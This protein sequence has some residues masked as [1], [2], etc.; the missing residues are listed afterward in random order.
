MKKERPKKV[1]GTWKCSLAK[2]GLLCVMA[3]MP[4][5]AQEATLDDVA[6]ASE[7][8]DYLEELVI[9][10]SADASVAGL[11]ESYNG[12][13]VARGGRVGV[14]GALDYM[15]TP[16]SSTNYTE[17]F[18]E[19]RQA[20][21]IGDVLEKDP[22]VRVARGFGNFQESYLIRGLQVYSDD[23]TFNG[24]YG[25][26]P[27]QYLAAE[28]AER[29][30]VFRGASAFLNGAAPTGS[31][32]GGTV[33]VLPKRAPNE[34]LNQ[35]TLGYTSDGQAYGA[36]D[37]ARRYLDGK[38]GVRLNTAVRDGDTAIDGESAGTALFALGL[39]WT[40]ERFRLSADLGYQEVK[41]QGIQPN[42]TVLPGVDIP[43]APSSSQSI[44]QSWTYADS[45]E[46]FGVLRAEYDFYENWSAWAAIGGRSG[47]EENRFANPRVS[48]VDGTANSY[49]FDNTREDTVLTGEVGV[50]GDFLT[51][52][53][54]HRPS[55]SFMAYSL[56]S[57][58]AYAFS[59]FG[60]FATNIYQPGTVAQPDATALIG[61]D[62]SNPSTTFEVETSSFALADMVSMF[63]ERLI[64]VGGLRYQSIE[65][66]SFDYNTGAEISNYSESELTPA[67][68]ALYKITPELAVYG[69][70]IEGLSAGDIAPASSG[71]SPVGNAG[72]ALD[73][74]VT[75]QLEF[76]TKLDYGTIGGSVAL[77]QT[78][79]PLAGIDGDGDY[80]VLGDQRYRGI[81]FSFFGEV[82]EGLRLLGGIS[83]L[84]TEDDGTDLI[85]A[86]SYQANLNVEWD[87]PFIE[88]FTFDAGMIHTASQYADSANTQ[89]VPS[90]T[91]FDIGGRYLFTLDDGK[92]ITLR[93]RVENLLDKDY[94]ASSGGYPGSGYLTVGGP[95]SLALSATYSF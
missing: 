69:N 11:P 53:V 8:P 3:A 48:N 76:G 63:D 41:L 33:N 78:E 13:Q 86:P 49:R 55:L 5:F 44:G 50:R 30:E 94:W 64:L 54:R 83:L 95:R 35:F 58:N 28:L 68:G 82:S 6:G 70:Y 20:Q 15:E 14:L 71:G 52:P 16:F 37:V 67:F 46:F 62:L 39:D 87:T 31:S 24:L 26:L 79:Q 10:A 57:K 1:L 61:G 73:P 72:E 75:E 23:M 65:T 32:L 89:K 74:Y 77:F 90:W 47:D 36:A 29:V 88:G 51:G 92:T 59:D 18:I 93:A 25:L 4:A 84:D 38:L 9:T 17:E 60:G 12:G 42:I 81:E 34:P 27:R 56:D 19:N 66:S 91:R 80:R 43:S 85:G 21:T 22:A 40:D 45:E 7:E 2:A